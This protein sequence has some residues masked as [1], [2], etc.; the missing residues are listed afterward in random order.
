[1]TVFD[2]AEEEWHKGYDLA[3]QHAVTRLGQMKADR[4]GNIKRWDAIRIVNELKEDRG[5]TK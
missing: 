2:S 3:V 1:M 5:R 4:K